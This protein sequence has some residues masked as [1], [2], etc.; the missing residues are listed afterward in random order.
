MC[1]GTVG[2]NVEQLMISAIAVVSKLSGL[3]AKKEAY[4]VGST[5][6]KEESFV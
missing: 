2:S 4:A 6:A 5:V 1:N 3:E